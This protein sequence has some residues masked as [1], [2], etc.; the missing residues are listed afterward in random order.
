MASWVG[1]QV[2]KLINV[3]ARKRGVN[4]RG[5]GKLSADGLKVWNSNERIRGWSGWHMGFVG[6]WCGSSPQ[7]GAIVLWCLLA[8]PRVPLQLTLC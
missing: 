6:C 3:K 8:Q 4:Q 1:H 5:N 7:L 2:G